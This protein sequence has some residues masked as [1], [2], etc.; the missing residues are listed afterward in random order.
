MKIVAKLLLPAIAFLALSSVSMEVSAKKSK[1][2][3]MPLED[4]ESDVEIPGSVQEVV[5]KLNGASGDLS[6]EDLNQAREAVAKLEV[7]LDIEK[8]LTDL[9]RVRK[10]R[11]EMQGASSQVVGMLPDNVW[12][13]ASDIQIPSAPSVFSPVKPVVEGPK[14]VDILQIF[15]AGGKYVAT[16]KDGSLQKRLSVGDKLEDGSRVSYISQRGVV[17]VKGKK[18]LILPVKGVG[19]VF[20]AR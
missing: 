4:V 6:M 9:T 10:E 15:G 17:L 19:H 11:D 8:K 12:K 14:E 16:Y 13:P 20:G 5:N 18:R 7:L 1:L 3:T 2:D